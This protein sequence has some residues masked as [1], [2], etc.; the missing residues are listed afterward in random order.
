[1]CNIEE[2]KSLK[3]FNSFGFDVN[4]HY[5]AA[6]NFVFEIKTLLADAKKRD[7]P[8]F[9]L[10]GGN[11]IVFTKDFDGLVICPQIEFIETIDE[12]DE[13]VF[14]SVGAGIVWDDF[15]Q[16]AVER[17]LGGVENLAGIP[18][19]VGAAP[20]QN[21]GAY[22]MEVKDSI[23]LVTGLF[24]DNEQFLL[25]NAGCKFGYRNSIFKNDLR[26]KTVI[27]YVIFKLSKHPEYNLDY[28]NLK[29]ELKKYDEVN[30][31]NI[32]NAV[33]DIRANKLPDPKVL[34]NAGSFFKNPVVKRVEAERL[35]ERFPA[36]PVYPVDAPDIYSGQVKLSAGWLIEQCGLKGYCENNIGVHNKQALILVNHG[37]GTATELISFSQM[38]QD[39]VFKKFDVK[40]EPEVIFVN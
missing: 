26:Q 8:V 20:V 23:S 27:T 39:R 34:G 33:I 13:N 7:I 4:A 2:N 35:L 30:L 14:V 38:V 36:I 12:N 31:R 29:D 25:D 16:Y 19:N 28:G 5:F 32:R 9:I 21:I 18:G 37:G 22:G 10:G 15:V 6:P 3:A 40:I 17:N 1:M 11:N 24:F